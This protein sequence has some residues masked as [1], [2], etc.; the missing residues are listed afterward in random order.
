M[1]RREIKMVSGLLLV[2]LFLMPLSTIET[3]VPRNEI[4]T[5]E[6]KNTI[7]TSHLNGGWLEERNGVKILHLNGSYYDMGYQ[8]GFLLKEEIKQGMRTQLSFFKDHG[9][10]YEKILEIWDIMDEYLP[11]EYKEEMQGMADGADMP[12]DDVIVSNTIPA[13]FNLA[14]EDACC[15]ISLWGDA[16]VDGKLF[17][18][19]SWDWRLNLSDPETGTS[20]QENMIVIIRTPEVGYA[21]MSVPEIPGA[22][23]SWNGVNEK[24]IV[25]GENTCITW[26]RT[27]QGICPAF[28]MRMVLDRCAT[29][30][31]ALVVLTS[32][33]TCGT[34]FVLSDANVPIGYALDQTGN[35]SYAGTWDDPIEGTDP[36]W[37]IKDVVRRTPTYIDPACAAVQYGRLRY[38]PSGLRGILDAALGR[39]TMVFPWIHYRAL[40]F[41]IEKYYGA[42]DVN[43]TMAALREEYI[44]ASDFWMRLAIIFAYQCLCQWVICPE[45]GDMAIS[46]ASSDTRAC[47]EPVHYFN[48]FELMDAEP[49]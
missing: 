31:E 1:R 7:A 38:D 11:N 22:I 14:F 27:F 40:S 2:V 9:Y 26:D 23:T 43:S 37:Q 25:V 32:N 18:V 39:S 19:R 6:E 12:L 44:G 34:N 13:I 21:S 24:G 3:T 47:Y 17:H 10:P 42:L 35:I 41:Q 5:F 8:H 45:T 28:R 20:L 30:E 46:F 49:P 16:T 36:F 15:E 33:R 29:G 4:S 48:I